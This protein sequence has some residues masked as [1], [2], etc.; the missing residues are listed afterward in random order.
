[1]D[2]GLI[3]RRYAKALYK[4]GV[5]RDCARD[6][7]LQMQTLEAA[8]AANPELQGVLANPFVSNKDKEQLLKTAAGENAVSSSTFG[9][10]LTLLAE[11]GRLDLARHIASAFID[12]FRK[13]NRIHSVHV[14]SAAPLSE[15][16]EQRI[17][18]IISEHLDGGTM[19]YSA[20]VRPDLIGGFVIT[21]DNQR[22]DASVRNELEKLRLNL[23]N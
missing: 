20:D 21:L 7:Y 17:R 6:L 18:Q 8:F 10:F 1:M 2:Q 5:E 11:N 15:R 12:L 13:E 9:D 14:T 23:I 19:E 3:P 22:L 4:V 16:N